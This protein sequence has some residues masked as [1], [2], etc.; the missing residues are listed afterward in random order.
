MRIFHVTAISLGVLALATLARA[1]TLT[2]TTTTGNGPYVPGVTYQADNPN[3]LNR[4]PFNFEG[5]VDWNLLKITTPSSVWEFVQ[6]GIHYQDDLEDFPSAIADYQ[7]ALSMNSLSNGTC[8]IFKT[9]PP[10]SPNVNPAPCMFTPRLRLAHLIVEDTPDLAISLYQE[11]LQID[12]LRLGVN[13]LIG[14]AW[15]I[16]AAKAADAA[17]KEAFLEK[18]IEAFNAELALSPVTAQYTALTGD[19]AN[20]A[21]VHWALAEI[22]SELGN[23]AKQAGE[24]QSYLDATQWHSD[25]YAWRIPL[26]KARLAKLTH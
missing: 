9:A 16:E 3:Y 19:K 6:R 17:S 21:H 7:K 24:L 20:N 23:T 2:G 25:T 8:Q 4:N 18:A 10:V 26:A 11:V 22:Y 14:E 15:E 13:E 12:A 5:R 1:Q